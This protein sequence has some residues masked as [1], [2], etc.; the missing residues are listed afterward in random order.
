MKKSEKIK[1]LLEALKA[2]ETGMCSAYL[3]A[4]APDGIELDGAD[5]ASNFST[6][7]AR[8]VAKYIRLKV[9]ND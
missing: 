4:Y 8:K 6:R 3:S 1:E 9:N 7:V 5:E 2:I